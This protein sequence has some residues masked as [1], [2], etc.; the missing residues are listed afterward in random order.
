MIPHGLLFL[1]AAAIV[2]L[3]VCLTFAR[4]DSLP[5][6]S[7]PV[8]IALLIDISDSMP[9]VYGLPSDGGVRLDPEYLDS[10]LSVIEQSIGYNRKIHVALVANGASAAQDFEIPP[11][12][13]DMEDL[14]KSRSVCKVTMPSI[15][16]FLNASL[17]GPESGYT[18]VVGALERLSSSDPNRTWQIVIASDGLQAAKR[19]MG[20]VNLEKNIVTDANVN[21]FVRLAGPNSPLTGLRGASIEFVVPVRAADDTRFANDVLSTRLFW[22]KWL[23]DYAPSAKLY[24]FETYAKPWN[25]AG[26]CQ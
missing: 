23:T 9:F 18:D 13:D 15:R 11:A 8:G 12:G 17:K 3:V 2:F 1:S 26:G 4:R 22:S 6:T 19:P 25:D 7:I 5:P 14:L 16:A 10:V 24:S 20:T 21:Q